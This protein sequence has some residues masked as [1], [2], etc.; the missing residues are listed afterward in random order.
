MTGSDIYEF[1]INIFLA[2]IEYSYFPSED[3]KVEQA[4]NTTNETLKKSLGQWTIEENILYRS[5]INIS[6]MTLLP[7]FTQGFKKNSENN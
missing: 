2:R 5:F 1:L 6:T 7:S 3:L 4:L